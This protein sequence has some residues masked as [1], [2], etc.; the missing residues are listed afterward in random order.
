MFLFC[1]VCFLVFLGWQYHVYHSFLRM[2]KSCCLISYKVI[3]ALFT[4]VLFLFC[5]GCLL[6]SVPI[7]I[8]F[9]GGLCLYVLMFCLLDI[10]LSRQVI[11]YRSLWFLKPIWISFFIVNLLFLIIGLGEYISVIVWIWVQLMSVFWI[12]LSKQL[13]SYSL[14]YTSI[15][16]VFRRLFF[17]IS[18]FFSVGMGLIWIL[19]FLSVCFLP[20][21]NWLPENSSDTCLDF[22]YCQSGLVIKY[23]DN[24][25][26]DIIVSKDLCLSQNFHWDENGQACILHQ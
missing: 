8:I 14:N 15:N 7:W 2:T 5:I 9:F 3:F 18:L 22:G 12:C 10:V 20:I 16:G 13:F 1:V 23:C 4:I 19:I 17:C 26:S 24:D 21:F 6:L 25:C 11:K